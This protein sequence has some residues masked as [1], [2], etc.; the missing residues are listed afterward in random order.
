MTLAIVM[1]L[2]AVILALFELNSFALEVKRQFLHVLF[3]FFVIFLFI[4]LYPS[5]SSLNAILWQA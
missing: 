2:V 5:L 4:S 3:L 1:A